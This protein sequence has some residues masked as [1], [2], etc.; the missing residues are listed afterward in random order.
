[1]L[2][3]SFFFFKQKTAYEMRISDWSSDV[4]SSDLMRGYNVLMPMG[5]DAF[6]MPADNAA[7]KSQVPPAKWTYDN[8]AYMEK[9]MHA[10]G[11][12]MDWSCAM[13]ACDPEYYKWNQSLYLKM[14]TYR[15]SD[16]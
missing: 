15:K 10:M 7:I 1:M 6:G 16:L 3:F 11:L 13:C 2:C 4:C 8:I 5:W 14:L 9:Q 12:A